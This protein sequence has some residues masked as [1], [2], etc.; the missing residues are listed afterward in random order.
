M[1]SVSSG[2]SRYSE[3]LTLCASTR[4]RSDFKVR[5]DAGLLAFI[6]FSHAEDVADCSSGRVADH[7]QATG[8]IAEAD[9]AC[10]AIVLAGVLDLE[11]EACK[12]QRCVLEIEATLIERL[13]SFGRIVA[14]T[15]ALL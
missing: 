14:D 9:H 8:E 3:G 2:S 13:L 6:G 15:H 7:D 1:A 10:L 12:D 11:G 4:L 5:A